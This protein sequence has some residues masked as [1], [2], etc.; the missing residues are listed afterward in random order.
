MRLNT[1]QKTTKAMSFLVDENVLVNLSAPSLGPLLSDG[2][3][4]RL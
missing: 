3:V 4:N 2:S 1:G